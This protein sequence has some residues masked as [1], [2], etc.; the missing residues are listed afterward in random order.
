MLLVLYN[1]N[2]ALTL[3]LLTISKLIWI[4][5]TKNIYHA[6]KN[7]LKAGHFYSTLG[8]SLSKINSNYAKLSKT[9]KQDLHVSSTFIH[10]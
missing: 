4:L 8:Y 5:L 7:L 9:Y 1:N 6:L 3:K 10:K 2:L